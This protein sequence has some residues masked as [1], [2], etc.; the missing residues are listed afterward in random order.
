MYIATFAHK[1][2]VVNGEKI[3]TFNEFQFSSSLETEKQ[4]NNGD[5][6]STYIKNQALGSFG[7][8][9]AL[10]RSLG[11][12]PMNQINDWMKILADKVPY[13][14]LLKGVPLLNT[15]WLLVDVSVSDTVVDIQ[16]NL[17]AAQLTLKF[18]EFA[19]QGSKKEASAVSAA[20][21]SSKSTKEKDT[22]SVYEALKPAA[23]ASLKTASVDFKKLQ[24]L[25]KMT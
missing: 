16:G 24:R 3:I 2:F 20:K 12:V 10:D 7:I 18:D 22:S 8:K 4:E 9:I 25:E 14:F 1:G 23:K 17:L 6:P 13:P 19:S 15:K 5:K 21:K 11:I